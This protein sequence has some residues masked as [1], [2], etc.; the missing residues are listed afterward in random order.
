MHKL[1]GLKLRPALGKDDRTLYRAPLRRPLPIIVVVV[2]FGSA[3]QSDYKAGQ[4]A[5][6]AGRNVEALTQWQAAAKA[7]DARAMLAL[8]RAYVKGQGVPQDYVE[9]H[10]WLNLAAA[11]GHADAASER[12]ALAEKM[13][14]DEQAEARRLA[15]TWRGGGR[16]DS[17]KS[18]AAIPRATTPS[19][20][21]PRAIREAQGLLAALGYEP[22]PTDGRWGPRTGRAHA[23]FLRDA[24][25]PPGNVLT[26]A[27]LRDM[28]AVAKRRNVAATEGS[29][30]QASAMPRKPAPPPAGLHRLVAAGDVDGLKAE[31]AAGADANARDGKGWT[32][33]MHAV[34][35]GHTLLVP[36]S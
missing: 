35:K 23:A 10:K 6:Q 32:A 13:T 28:R 3:A 30:P 36:C 11:Q 27:A 8:G 18:A 19:S 20:P 16:T 17:P 31:L 26:P 33:L 2:L 22:G 24:G 21:P 34:D 5:W 4:S 25:L 15:R 1:F 12:D 29:P 7:G 9:A 14:T